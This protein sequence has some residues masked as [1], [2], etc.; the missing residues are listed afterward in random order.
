MPPN[1]KNDLIKSVIYNYSPTYDNLYFIS[2]IFIDFEPIYCTFSIILQPLFLFTNFFSTKIV[3]FKI[4]MTILLL[5]KFI[6]K[7]YFSK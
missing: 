1:I 2:I 4:H 5:F 3:P 7:K 6:S